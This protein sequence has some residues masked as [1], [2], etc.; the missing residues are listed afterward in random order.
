MALAGTAF[1]YPIDGQ[2]MGSAMKKWRCLVCDFVY[3][4]AKGVPE[5]GIKPGTRWEDVP[6]DWTCPDCGAGKADFQ[7]EEID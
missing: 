6:D 1:L 5:E 2:K 7:M 3:D 4:E